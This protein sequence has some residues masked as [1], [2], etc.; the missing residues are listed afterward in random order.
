MV[1]GLAF[2]PSQLIFLNPKLQR[3]MVRGLAFKPSQL[4]EEVLPAA[5][6]TI[7]IQPAPWN[8]PLEEADQRVHSPQLIL[9]SGVEDLGLR[10]GQIRVW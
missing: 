7:S 8:P 6:N 10:V 9:A 5:S 4:L 3:A 2:K 1:R